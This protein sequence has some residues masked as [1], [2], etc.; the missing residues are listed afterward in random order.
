MCQFKQCTQ[1]ELFLLISFLRKK[2]QKNNDTTT[3]TKNKTVV[4]ICV[5][6]K[7]IRFIC[8]CFTKKHLKSRI[9]FITG[10]IEPSEP[11]FFTNRDQELKGIEIDLIAPPLEFYVGARVSCSYF[12]VS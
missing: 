5:A 11:F 3:K 4:E 12:T 7:S 6:Y 1:P 8:S 9:S 10:A 2:S